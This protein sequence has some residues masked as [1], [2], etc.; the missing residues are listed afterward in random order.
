MFRLDFSFISEHKKSRKRCPLCW[1][2]FAKMILIWDCSPCWLKLKEFVCVIVTHPF[3]DLFLTIC[4]I[5]NIFFLAL[6]CYPMSEETTNVLSIGNLVRLL[7]YIIFS[8]LSHHYPIILFYNS[9]RLQMHCIST[10][11]SIVYASPL[12]HPKPCFI[13][14]LITE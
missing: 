4:I 12:H 14:V 8:F 11:W 5:L 9:N 3:T 10:R 7:L 6:E 13:N 1:Y 2:K